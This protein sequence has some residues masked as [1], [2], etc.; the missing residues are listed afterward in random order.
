MINDFKAQSKH[1]QEL[2]M[3]AVTIVLLL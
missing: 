1:L 3:P 2:W